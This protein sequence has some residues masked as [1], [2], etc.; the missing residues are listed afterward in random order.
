[1]PRKFIAGSAFAIGVIVA[2]PA[3]AQTPSSGT[4]TALVDTILRRV[5]A[6]SPVT[7][8]EFDQRRRE[9]RDG[10]A[11]GITTALASYPLGA[12]SAGLVY[13][14]G[15][16]KEPILKST[17]FGS[18]FVERSVTNGRGTFNLGVSY[19]QSGFDKL[20][21]IDL[22]NVGFPTQSQLGTYTGDGSGVGD[23]FFAKLD[24]KSRVF[25]FS[26]SYGV[27][28]SLDVG[29]AVPIASLSVRG[30]LIREYDA[31]HDFVI[32][33][34]I[35]DAYPNKAGTLVMTDE[36]VDASG[37]GDVMMRVK[38]AFG[39]PSDQIAMVAA[40][41]RLPTGDEENM[42]GT[43]KATFKVSAGS[44]RNFGAASLNVNGGYTAGLTDELNFA[45]GADVALLSRKQLTVSFDFI[46][47]RLLDTV[48]SI[49]QEIS[50][51]RV[52]GDGVVFL[53]RRV[54]ISYGF[55]NQGATT[56]NRAAVGAKYNFVGNWLLTAS[57]VF[58]LNDNGF[59]SKFMGLVGLERSWGR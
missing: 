21:G 46:S 40:E 12:S 51:D 56:L 37:L 39:R 8:A 54:V 5:V 17:S 48:V 52:E 45:A 9:T 11:I 16:N 2:A 19:Q 44:T 50:R 7:D 29:W 10:I 14:T 47:Q 33:Q 36:T 15:P 20:Q 38:Y 43:G 42:L 6:D 13:I 55:W 22:K 49:G 27:T 4:V 3:A 57:G 31:G 58:R 34:A 26:G 18:M 59:Q 41:L 25:V 24:V 35:Q 32:S 1:M 23:A 53:P 30:Q 28:D